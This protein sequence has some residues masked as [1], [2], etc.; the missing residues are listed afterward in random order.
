MFAPRERKAPTPRETWLSKLRAAIRALS[1][2]A[3]VPKNLVLESTPVSQQERALV[4]VNRYVRIG[5]PSTQR[6][7]PL[8]S[9]PIEIREI[10]YQHV[11]GPSLVH[12]LPMG[13]RLVHVSCSKWP[14][15]E[16]CDGHGHGGPGWEAETTIIDVAENPN[17]QL[18]ALCL[19]CRVMCVI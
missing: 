13:R 4:S 3:T 15:G 7:F 8:L 11:F 2:R 1:K 17:D 16:S 12:I 18:L 19:S 6:Q 14:P 5:E 9:L 10:V